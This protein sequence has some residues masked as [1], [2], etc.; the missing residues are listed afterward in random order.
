MRKALVLVL[1]VLALAG[2]AVVAY[3]DTVIF[4]DSWGAN[5]LSQWMGEQQ[6][7]YGSNS[8]LHAITDSVVPSP[9]TGDGQGFVSKIEYIKS[10]EAWSGR[11]SQVGGGATGVANLAGSTQLIWKAR[12]DSTS[13]PVVIDKFTCKD[14]A[15]NDITVSTTT[16]FTSGSWRSYASPAGSFTGRN[17]TA[18]NGVFSFFITRAGNPISAIPIIFYLDDVKYVGGTSGIVQ[19]T[20]DSGVVGVQ[21]TQI[22]N[23][24][25]LTTVNANTSYNSAAISPPEESHLIVKNVGT[26]TATYSLNLT[27]PSPWVAV[28]TGTALFPGSDLG[29]DAYALYG[30]FSGTAEAAPGN[31]AYLSEDIIIA[32]PPTSATAS[33]YAYTTTNGVGVGPT[34]ERNLWIGLHTPTASSVATTQQI[35]ITITARKA[36]P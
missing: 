5:P 31:A 13:T 18:V 17:M 21:V 35:S 20:M 22:V 9:F 30:L 12:A 2:L 10:K 27:N 15:N 7:N 16:S 1:A 23:F 25:R 34:L 4:T 11:G 24:D 28:N 32:D 3:A 36:T 33:V 14:S 29:T 8:T 19:V 26:D 6:L